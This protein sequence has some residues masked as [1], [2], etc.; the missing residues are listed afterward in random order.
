[1]VIFNSYVKLPEGMTC[2]ILQIEVHVRLSST[3]LGL[4]LTTQPF[5][6]R[7]KLSPFPDA[8][9]SGETWDH[10][11]HVHPMF[12]EEVVLTYPLVMS[13]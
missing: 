8:T 2:L 5:P 1:M 6:R 13:K 10:T 4:V 3:S 9:D 7:S 11:C 12:P